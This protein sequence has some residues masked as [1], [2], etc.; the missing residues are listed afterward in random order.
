M[1]R[2]EYYRMFKV[3]DEHFWYKGMRTISFELLKKYLGG[4]KGV[5]ILDAGC[6]TGANIKWLSQYGQVSGFDISDLA[7]KL[8]KKRG[9]TSAV[10]GSIEKIPFP[11]NHFDVVICF[12][13]LGQKQIVNH[14]KAIKELYRVLKPGG[15][16]LLRVAAYDWLYSYHDTAVQTKHRYSAGE[17]RDLFLSSSFSIKRITYANM[18]LFPISLLMRIKSRIFRDPKSKESDVQPIKG[19]LNGF[20]Y[21]F[22]LLESLLIRFISLP[23]GLSVMILAKKK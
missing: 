6:G 10:E 11:K 3:E 14:E 20:F 9:I 23:F 7:I 12:D 13:V 19:F 4:K 1:Q 5:T 22:L 8:C 18:L 17:L 16:I 15:V 2:D 21:V